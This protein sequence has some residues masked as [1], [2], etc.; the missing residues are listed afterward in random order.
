MGYLAVSPCFTLLFCLCLVQQSFQLAWQLKTLI[1]F[2]TT[3]AAFFIL[4]GLNNKAQGCGTPLPWVNVR[5][6]PH[7]TLKGLRS[8]DLR[9]P[10]RV[11]GR[12]WHRF[13]R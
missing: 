11:E 5:Q 13:P 7:P 3:L 2:R 4:K 12:L 9:N 8:A 1:R 6:S 10:F